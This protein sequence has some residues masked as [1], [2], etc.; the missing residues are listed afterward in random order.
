MNITNQND[1]SLVTSDPNFN[2]NENETLVGTVEAS[3]QDND[4]VTFSVSGSDLAIT[5]AGI[6][7]FISAPDYE[8]KSSFSAIVTASDGS[9]TTDQNIL[10]SVNN[11][12]DNS[13]AFKSSSS[14]SINENQNAI[15]TVSAI[16]ADGDTVGSA[17]IIQI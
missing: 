12:N 13:P 4:S 5:S 14:F 2:I 11:V 9:N 7:S 3:D 16:D 10:V 15:G 1:F 6:L 8:S 17:L